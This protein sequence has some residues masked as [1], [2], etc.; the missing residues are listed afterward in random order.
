MA[1]DTN[2]TTGR[3]D[4]SRQTQQTAICVFTYTQSAYKLPQFIII[5]FFELRIAFWVL[6]SF[7]LGTKAHCFKHLCIQN[8]HG[9]N[10]RRLIALLASPCYVFVIVDVK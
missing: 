2:F 8:N 7:F 10:E 1:L 5:V 4:Q 9:L 6:K 3:D